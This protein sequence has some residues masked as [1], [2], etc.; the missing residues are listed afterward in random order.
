[1]RNFGISTFRLFRLRHGNRGLNQI[2]GV[3]WLTILT[4]L[5][6]GRA[7]FTSG[8]IPPWAFWRQMI[9][10][11]ALVAPISPPSVAVAPILTLDIPL[12]LIPTDLGEPAPPLLARPL[13]LRFFVRRKRRLAS[14]AF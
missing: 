3:G 14:I 7:Q 9:F 2:C 12:H 6:G 5:R 8:R 4:A 1:M 10:A 13:S 11:V